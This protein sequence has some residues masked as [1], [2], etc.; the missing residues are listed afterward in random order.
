MW[1]EPVQG[2]GARGPPT[3]LLPPTRLLHAACTHS[4]ALPSA[5]SRL[6]HAACAHSTAL[7]SALSVCRVLLKSG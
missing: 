7:P 5:T 3:C 2:P 1:R 4:T 6:L